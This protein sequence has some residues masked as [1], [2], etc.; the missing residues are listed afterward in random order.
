VFELVGSWAQ[1]NYLHMI[2]EIKAEQ[3]RIESGALDRQAAIDEEAWI[4]YQKDPHLAREFLTT[5]CVDNANDAL[6]DWRKLAASL[7]TRYSYGTATGMEKYIAPEW[8]RKEIAI[9][10]NSMKAN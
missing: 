4:L 8:W 5:Y 10:S 1:L 6:A 7:I 2:K 9:K 3:L